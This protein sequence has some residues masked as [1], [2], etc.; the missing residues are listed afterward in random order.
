VF[1]FDNGVLAATAVVSSGRKAQACDAA[2]GA[3]DNYGCA[4]GTCRLA[5]QQPGHV[6]VSKGL[7]IAH[8]RLIEKLLILE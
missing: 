2:Q 4:C 7:I 8:H 3:E 6:V 1:A 5:R